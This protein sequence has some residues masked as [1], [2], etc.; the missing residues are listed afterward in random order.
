LKSMSLQ[1]LG[2]AMGMNS[3]FMLLYNLFGFGCPDFLMP[4]I[5]RGC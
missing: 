4:F 5:Y 3:I 2:K 1:K